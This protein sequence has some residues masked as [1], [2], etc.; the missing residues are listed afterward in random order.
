MLE[1]G[2][3]Y[4]DFLV[5]GLLGMSLMSGGLWGVGFAI[6]HARSRRLLKR[7]VA[8]PMSRAH[9]LLSHLIWRLMILVVEVAV[10]VGFGVLAFGVPVRGSLLELVLLCVLASLTFSAM[11]LLIASR[12]RTI[13]GV[14]GLMNL[15]QVPMWILSGVFFSAQ[16]FPDLLQPLVKVLPLTAAIDALRGNMLQGA[17]LVDLGP[18]IAVLS[19]W[20]SISFVLALKLFR[21]R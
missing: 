3:R 6:V 13:E 15:A 9:Y 8:T 4:I 14:S 12:A 1:P 10:P 5:P 16:R 2:S 19:A 7:L 20:L 17:R 11:G 21:W 18:E